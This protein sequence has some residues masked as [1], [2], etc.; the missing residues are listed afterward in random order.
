[1]TARI[2]DNQLKAVLFII[3]FIVLTLQAAFTQAQSFKPKGDTY[4]GLVAS[5]GTRSVEVSSDIAQIDGTNL[6]ATGGRVGLIFGNEFARLKTGLLGY[7]SS[8]GNTPGTTDLYQSN[9]GVNLYPLA[10]ITVA[11]LLIEPYFTGGVSYDRFKFFG[12]YINQ[13]PGI[14]NYSQGVAPFLGKIK[15]VNATVGMGL[16]LKLRDRFDFIH[17]F[18]EAQYGR[19]L[20]SKASDERFAATSLNNQLQVVVG[21]T[22][23]AHN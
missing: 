3:L 9:L 6:M 17:L 8:T 2:K 20:S 7:Y 19:N 5:F 4:R 12:Y 22:F 11:Q 15:Q 21:V 13:E 16:E 23:G 18:C 10:L 1:M 14:T